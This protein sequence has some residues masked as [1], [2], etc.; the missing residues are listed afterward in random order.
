RESCGETRLI[1]RLGHAQ[2]RLPFTVALELRNRG[3]CAVEARRWQRPASE[4]TGEGGPLHQPARQQLVQLAINVQAGRWPS[5]VRPDLGGHAEYLLRAFRWDGTAYVPRPLE[6][7]PDVARLKRDRELLEELSTWLH[8]HADEVD[9]GFAV[10]PE[11]FL[12]EV[13]TSVTPRG[14]ARLANRPFTQL[15]VPARFADVAPARFTRTPEAFLR[16]LDDLSCS[17]CHQ[18]RAVA[19]FHQLGLDDDAPAANALAIGHS[20]HVH[21]DLPRRAAYVEAL[22]SGHAPEDARPFAEHSGERG[23]YG[24]HCGLADPS[25]AGWTCAPGLHCDG[26]E[27]DP[28]VG[29]CLGDRGVGDPCEPSRV[30]PDA[31][32]HR[33]RARLESARV[34]PEVCEATRVGF[35]SGMCAGGCGAP[36]STCGA[37]AVLTPFNECLARG[38]PFVDCAT[39]HSRPAG[40]R[41]CDLDH[42]CRDDYLCARTGSGKGACLPPYFVLQMRVDGHPTPR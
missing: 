37:I 12:A 21:D 22:A 39:Q 8:A 2:S 28:A 35:P 1:Y 16:R 10:I 9:Q 32:P 33:D 24:A 30:Q 14:F 31:D 41:G 13:A 20:P 19:G 23:E 27:G 40:L 25:F 7:T 17:G 6:N 36:G 4:L 3:D 5:A 34:C 42:P 38:Q 29:V 26:F 18:A 15:F 11:R